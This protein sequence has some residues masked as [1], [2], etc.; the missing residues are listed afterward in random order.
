MVIRAEQ[1]P[2]AVA[3]VD[4]DGSHTIRTAVE[5]ATSLADVFG[6][7]D[8]SP[9][10]VVIQADNTWGTVAA[11]LAVGLAGG[12]VAV[13][14]PHATESEFAL[15]LEDIRPDVVVG[16]SET[17]RRWGV[18]DDRFPVEKPVFGPYRVRASNAPFAS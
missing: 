8:P 3:V 12:V 6:G 15:A 10:T 7:I 14:S 13:V 2:D 5:A 4:E 1:T 18:P 17:L 16:T 9:P 11:A